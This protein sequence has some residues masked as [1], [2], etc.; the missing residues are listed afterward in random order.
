M[1]SLKRCVHTV[2]AE[3]TWRKICDFLTVYKSAIGH[4]LLGRFPTFQSQ[5]SH[6]LNKE[7]VSKIWPRNHS[8]IEPG[9]NLVPALK[10]DSQTN[11]SAWI[12]K[13]RKNEGS[14][15]RCWALDESQRAFKTLSHEMTSCNKVTQSLRICSSVKK[16]GAVVHYELTWFNVC[17]NS[18]FKGNVKYKWLI[19]D[20]KTK[21]IQVNGPVRP[22]G[23]DGAFSLTIG[24]PLPPPMTQTGFKTTFW[25]RVPK[26]L[27]KEAGK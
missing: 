5:N 12:V 23:G 2:K 14:S 25:L 9:F 18:V 3:T 15:S 16:A 17:F 26:L 22:V 21:T 13:W 10:R 8:W 7:G 11:N 4:F 27:P 19:I 1:I 20:K 24:A 6:R